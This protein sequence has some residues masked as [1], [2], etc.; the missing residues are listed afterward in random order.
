MPRNIIKID[1]GKDEIK[2]HYELF[3]ELYNHTDIKGYVGKN[4][5][6]TVY[7]NDPNNFKEKDI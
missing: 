3:R 5:L 1:K 4:M 6:A 7:V 2:S